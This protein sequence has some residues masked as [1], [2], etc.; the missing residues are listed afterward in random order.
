MDRIAALLAVRQMR[1]SRDA[2][3]LENRATLPDA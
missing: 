2:F 1:L 3:V